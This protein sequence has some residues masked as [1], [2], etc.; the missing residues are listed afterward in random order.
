MKKSLSLA[1]I[2]F[3]LFFPVWRH[4]LFAQSADDNRFIEVRRAQI[5]LNEARASL[6]RV[7]ELHDLG[8]GSRLDVDNARLALERA[9]LNY[10]SS[11]LS[12]LSIQPRLSV[13]EA[14]KRQ[15]SDGRRFV[16]ITLQN[17]TPVFD[18]ARFQ[19]L[20]NFEGADPI[21]QEL[22]TRDVTDIFVSLQSAGGDGGVSKATIAIPY[23]THIEKLQYGE[24]RTLEFQL[25]RDVDSLIV[26]TEHR[27]QKQESIVH[28]QQAETDS[29][30]MMSSLQVSQEADLG[31][32]VTFELRLERS[33]VDVRRFQLKAVNLPR[34]IGHGFLDSGSRRLSQVNFPTGVTQ[35]N[36]NL[37]LNLPDRTSG[38]IVIDEP[39]EFWALA[40]DDETARQFAEE[41]RYTE[42]EIERSRAGRVRLHLQ[43]RGVGKIEAA[44]PS[45]FSEILTGETVEA[46]MTLRN[47]GTRRVDNIR[48]RAESPLNW[49]V[50]IEPDMV[51]MLEV[52]REAEVKFVMIPPENAV[53]GD[54]EVRIKT[55]SYSYNRALPSDD[56]LYRVS[57]KSQPNVWATAGLIAGLLIIL[58]GVA[59]FLVKLTRR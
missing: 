7:Q 40:L 32:E 30:L 35:Q 18:D 28:L 11:V 15:D 42:E 50:E 41:R 1:I 19:L 14:M 27:G 12:L 59:V 43:P 25:L 37:R 38:E 56:K 17:L 23:E 26:A 16:L 58:A 48:I 39:I 49:R 20:N 53:V 5:A 4:C 31:A 52:G 44:A 33:S 54:Y 3:T 13:Q 2:I 57:I 24:S 51:E 46:K 34:Q 9:Q 10:Q 22:R 29:A 45:L 21:P 6:A 36:L 8:I 55:E 47:S